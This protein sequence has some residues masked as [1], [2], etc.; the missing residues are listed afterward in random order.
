[1][2]KIEKLFNNKAETVQKIIK[3]IYILDVIAGVLGGII[4]AIALF[5]EALLAFIVLICGLLSPII[6]WFMLIIPY[7]VAE[8]AKNSADIL[9]ELKNRPAVNMTTSTSVDT[10]PDALP[11][12]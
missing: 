5:E 6:F 3:V 10:A 1:M 2:E 8:S 4:V 9:A 7:L 12:F 11:E